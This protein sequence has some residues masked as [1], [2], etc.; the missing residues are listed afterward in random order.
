MKRYLALAVAPLVWLAL[1]IPLLL[2]SL[3]ILSSESPPMTAIPGFAAPSEHGCSLHHCRVPA[4][5]YS[6]Q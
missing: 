6:N 2:V 5:G 1:M 3:P 4:A